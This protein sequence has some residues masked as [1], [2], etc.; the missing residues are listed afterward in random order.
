[1]WLVELRHVLAR[2]VQ[3]GKVGLLCFVMA[4]QR[5]ARFGRHVKARLGAVWRG[6]AGMARHVEFWL[7]AVRCGTAGTA[8]PGSVG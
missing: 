4:R 2:H 6:L 8:R 7:G 5:V 3:A 1:M